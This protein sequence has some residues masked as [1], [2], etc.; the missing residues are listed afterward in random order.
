MRSRTVGIRNLAIVAASLGVLLGSTPARAADTPDSWIT[1]KTKIA[2][3]TTEDLHTGALNVDTVKGV[4]TLHGT[5][6]NDAE[7]MKAEQVA[8]K[9]NGAKAVKNLLQVVPGSQREV[10]ERADSVV[11]DG[12]EA[13]FKAN[14][15]ITDSGI[16][17]ASVNKGAVLLSGKTHSLEAHYESIEVAN[18]VRGVHRVS[19]EVDVEMPNN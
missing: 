19:T 10:V 13:A 4:V 11:K 9:V 15:R 14:R 16:K 1:L 6:V 12:V 8:M 17:V 18:A 7:K 2:L 5:V 3:M